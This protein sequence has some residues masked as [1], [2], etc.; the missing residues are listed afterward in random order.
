[1]SHRRKM[2][3]KISKEVNDSQSFENHSKSLSLL[4]C[5]RSEQHAL[6]LA[7]KFKSGIL[8][9]FKHFL[10]CVEKEID[11]HYYLTVFENHP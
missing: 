11:Y 2:A 1:M 9:I 3:Q 8:R 7:R 6:F 10:T 5:E 4:H